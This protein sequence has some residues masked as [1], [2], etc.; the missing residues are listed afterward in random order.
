MR[1]AHF[2]AGTVGVGH[3]VHGFAMRRALERA[4]FAGEFRLFGPPWSFPC[5]QVDWYAPTAIEGE[6]LLE[7]SR[8]DGCEL[9]RALL[10]YRPDLLIVEL[11]WP[12]IH[13]IRRL[14]DCEVWLLLRKCVDQWF[15]GPPEAPYDPARWDRI[16]A[17]EPIEHSSITH[18]IDPIVCVNPD[19]CR[20]DTA[21]RE[22]LQVP[23]DK[24]LA[25][26]AH[27]GPIEEQEAL[28][29]VGEE[30][31]HVAHFDLN[32]SEA[33]FPLAE[34]LPGADVIMT[35]A[36]YNT[37]WESK[38]LGFYDR[39]FFTA[40]PRHIDDQAWRVREC[41]DHWPRENGADTLARWIME[42]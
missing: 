22:Y 17:M 23:D 34:W 9:T 29:A 11:F 2:T 7:G 27:T 28:A 33:L 30:D 3:Y 39:C 40:F 35:G 24:T 36:G 20:P 15:V 16:I 4:G 8:A 26:V 41:A 25:V 13:H 12:P 14:F 31:V 32:D 5:A 10:E 1:I 42:R 18:R 19:E 6:T 37:Y 21:L 38:W